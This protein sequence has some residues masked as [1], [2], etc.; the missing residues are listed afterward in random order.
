MEGKVQAIHDIDGP[1]SGLRALEVA[2]LHTRVDEG[3][4]MA[5]HQNYIDPLRWNPL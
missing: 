1:D 2:V 5:N 4:L 3:L